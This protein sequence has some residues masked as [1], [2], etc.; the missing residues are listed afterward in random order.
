MPLRPGLR[1]LRGKF[2][3]FVCDA[4]VCAQILVLFVAKLRVLAFDAIRTKLGA[5]LALHKP[6]RLLCV[7]SY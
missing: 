3:A 6:G 1:G 7:P 2:V 5:F 4:R